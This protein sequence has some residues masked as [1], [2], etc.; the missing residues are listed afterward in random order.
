MTYEKYSK[1]TSI[2]MNS[3]AK[4]ITSLTSEEALD[5]IMQSDQ[6]HNFELPEY[7]DFKAVLEYV[8]LTIGEKQ[9]KD[10]IST[11]P[12][13]ELNDVN[14][15]ILLNKD[16]KYAVRPLVLCNPYLYY[17]LA[18][19]LCGKD[20][21]ETVKGHFSKCTVAHITSCALPV[22]PEKVEKF[23]KST[24]ILNWWNSMEQ[25]ALELSLDYRYMFV[26]DITNCYG[27]VNPQTIDWALA[28]K[29]TGTPTDGNHSIAQNIIQY[30][31]DFQQGRNIG[32][33][34]GSTLFDLT[35]EIILC[36]SDLLLSEALEREGIEEDYEILRYRDDYRIF[37]NDKDKL[38]KISYILQQVLE[39]LNFRM[40]SSKTFISDSIISDSIKP[41][42]L[43]YIYNT[44]IFN[45]KGCDF[46][47]L[48]KHLLYIMM[49]ARKYP[50]AGQVRTMLNDLDERIKK[51]LEPHAKTY[52]VMTLEETGKENSG[53][54]EQVV[55]YPGK[56]I[57]N[58]KVL[59]AICTQIAVE[60]VSVAHYALRV[61]SRMVDSIKDDEHRNELI[62]K[63]CKKLINQ[64]NSTYTKLWLQ[65]M[66]YSQDVRN[67]VSPYDVRLCKVVMGEDV[68]IWNNSWLKEELI[69]DFPL[70]SVTNKE[71]LAKV[72]PIITFRETRNYIEAIEDDDMSYDAQDVVF[73]L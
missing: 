48:Q 13:S 51:Q 57:E 8:R 55:E 12:A 64:P 59:S 1:Q 15:D 61:I 37:C 41:D 29:N 2:N 52:Q 36:Y 65:N 70:T 71:T 67:E 9:Y 53:F 40:N 16:G 33:P 17:F 11:P 56:I 68:Q 62:S 19:E 31:K 14:H 73:T 23:H 27:S 32:I 35:C 3:K 34:Q 6:F 43:F 42:K 25:K 63:V 49:F 7:F 72:T 4:Y 20:N 28:R 50:N 39:T 54:K 24:T 22:V 46:D 10:C 60:N 58:I 47:G 44:P 66:T 30:L 45:K 26:T 38:E 21:W 69:K 18:R 5:F